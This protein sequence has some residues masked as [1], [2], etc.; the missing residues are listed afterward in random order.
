M[1]NRRSR[2]TR[3]PPH[4]TRLLP[5][6]LQQYQADTLD[7]PRQGQKHATAQWYRD[8]V[9]QKAQFTQ[10]NFIRGF[11]ITQREY[12]NLVDVA[13]DQLKEHGQ[14]LDNKVHAKDASVRLVYDNIKD[15]LKADPTFAFLNRQSILS[16]WAD[17]I[18]TKFLTHL[19]HQLQKF[20]TPK[21]VRA[22]YHGTGTSPFKRAKKDVL[23][24]S[25]CHFKITMQVNEDYP[26]TV[27][28]NLSA[29]ELLSEAEDPALCDDE[30][31]DYEY[32]FRYSVIVQ[33]SNALLV[34]YTTSLSRRL[35]SKPKRMHRMTS[36]PYHT[37]PTYG[38]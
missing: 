15:T 7:L 16:R 36:T 30:D 14:D 29:A 25:K 4:K 18:L 11:N 20:S 3:L 13:S 35:S 1:T 6:R 10:K 28:F 31:V 38:A 8:Q 2:K 21:R 22:S 24:F 5:Q 9:L 23:P 26:G 37:W 34:L 17:D 33:S 12:E 32:A 19:R 27:L